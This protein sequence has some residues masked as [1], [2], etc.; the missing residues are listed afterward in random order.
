[1]LT[2]CLLE[3]F[4]R[5]SYAATTGC[6]PCMSLLTKPTLLPR[7]LTLTA[8]LLLLL[9]LLSLIPGHHRGLT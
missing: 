8:L 1:M 2:L 7:T 4:M 5:L 6:V 3:R 9:L